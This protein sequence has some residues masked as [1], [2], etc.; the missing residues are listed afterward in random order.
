M[1]EAE[2]K[3]LIDCAL[4]ML[5]YQLISLTGGNVSMRMGDGTFLVTPSGMLYESMKMDDIVQIDKNN[6]RI[7]GNRRQTSD[8]TALLYIYK[9]K[10]DVNAIIHTHQPYAT[11][12][13]MI[14]KRLPA[15]TTGIIAVGHGD[16]PVTPFT[17]SS[18]IGMGIETVKY[19]GVSDAVILGNHGVIGMGK[20]LFDAL[21]AVVY[22]EEGA[23]AYLMAKTAGDI[24]ELTE[25]EFAAENEESECYGQ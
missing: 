24:H 12:V 16:V 2:K 10:P 4:E 3:Q 9:H 17:V 8:S 22:L 1:Y 5:K 11:A 23:K 19:C 13:G 6:D 25:K 18:D 14:G 7:S 21:E 20:T 15:C